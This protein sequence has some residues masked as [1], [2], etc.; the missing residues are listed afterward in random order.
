M[1]CLGFEPGAAGWQAQTKPRSYGGQSLTLRLQLF[2][3][4]IGHWC[5]QHKSAEI[6][7][8]S[9]KLTI[10]KTN[11]YDGRPGPVVMG[12]DSCSKGC[13]FESRHC[14]LDRHFSHLFVV[15]NYN[16]C[17]KRQ[18]MKKRPGLAHK[19]TTNGCYFRNLFWIKVLI[20]NSG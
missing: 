10:E 20:A 5:W 1:V 15:T 2:Y 13:E 4:D 17:L 9:V 8:S 11:G 14:I 7:G 18:K 19:K 6:Q 12:G 3:D 16:V